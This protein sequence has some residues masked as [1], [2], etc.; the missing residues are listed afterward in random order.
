ME[1]SI[2]CTHICTSGIGGKENKKLS[3]NT[4]ETSKF[5]LLEFINFEL[6]IQCESKKQPEKNKSTTA[7]CYYDSASRLIKY[8]TLHML[9]SAV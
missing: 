1:S 7:S 3:Q 5:V 9:S 2:P 8:L 4:R 6:V